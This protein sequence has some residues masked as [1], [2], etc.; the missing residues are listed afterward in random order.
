MSSILKKIIFISKHIDYPTPPVEC[1]SFFTRDA[2]E[3]YSFYSFRRA[4]EI[5]SM[6]Q[7]KKDISVQKPDNADNV[8]D[9]SQINEQI[10][11]PIKSDG[12]DYLLTRMLILFF[13]DF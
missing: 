7:E 13:T 2:Y 5:F 10:T 9:K 6:H 3:K 11:S 4:C 8:I 1:N 12:K